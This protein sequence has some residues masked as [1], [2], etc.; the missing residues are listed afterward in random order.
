MP[1]ER[2]AGAE[3]HNTPTIGGF[4]MLPPVILSTIPRGMVVMKKA[5]I[6]HLRLTHDSDNLAIRAEASVTPGSLARGVGG[7]GDEA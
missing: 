3:G 6:E 4:V 5:T 7:P 2:C 1:P